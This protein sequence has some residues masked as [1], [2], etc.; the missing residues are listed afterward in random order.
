MSVSFSLKGLINMRLFELVS[1]A[2]LHEGF[3]EVSNKFTS[4]IDNQDEVAKYI[5]L[6]KELS[7]KNQLSG[8]EKNIDSWG[9]RPFSEF[10]QFIDQKSNQQTRTSVK[11]SKNVGK[12]ITLFENEEWLIVVPLNVDASCYHGK[13]TDWCTAKPNDNYFSKYFF[14]NDITL[15]YLLKIK[16]GEKWAI[17]YNNKEDTMELFDERDN[18]L[19]NGDFIEETGIYPKAVVALAKKNNDV[20][21]LGRVENEKDDME[22][23]FNRAIE[24]GQRNP[25]LERMIQNANNI[26]VGF[27]YMAYF[28]E[29]KFKFPTNVILKAFTTNNGDVLLNDVYT[30]VDLPDGLVVKGDFSIATCR[31]FTSLP[32]NLTVHG[33]LFAYKSGLTSLPK[34]LKVGGNISILDTNI[35]SIPQD[36]EVGGNVYITMGTMPV[37]YKDR[38]KPIGINGEVVFRS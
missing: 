38:L 12:S 27:K 11:R 6:Y 35:K 1:S 21:Q 14:N 7:K 19:F 4:E 26:K 8:D 9:K 18:T 24:D 36:I 23:L 30:Q 13:N 34:N 22:F 31:E 32:T 3:K 37:T 29:V 20:I 25:K 16:T 17:A 5:E 10:K 2:Y 33:D 28:P 15:I